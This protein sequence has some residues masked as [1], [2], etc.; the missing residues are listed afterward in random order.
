MNIDFEDIWSALSEYRYHYG[1]IQHIDSDF[2]S[3]LNI[4]DLTY[5]KCKSITVRIFDP[6]IESRTS[7]DLH[8]HLDGQRMNGVHSNYK[9]IYWI[10]GDDWEE[11]GTK[12]AYNSYQANMEVRYDSKMMLDINR[13][14]EELGDEGIAIRPNTLYSYDS[15]FVHCGRRYK[16]N[17]RRIFIRLNDC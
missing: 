9:M 15:T 6:K 3:T 7:F 8:F 10:D 14:M 2:A 17:S 4:L 1:P 12:F 16:G 13:Q 11:L 5:I